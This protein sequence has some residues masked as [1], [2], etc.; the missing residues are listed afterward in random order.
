MA[1]GNSTLPICF[2]KIILQTNLQTI[3]IPNKFT[4]SHGVGLPNPMFIKPPD[5]TKWKM[6]WKNIN[7]EIWF[8]KGWSIFTQNYSLQHGCLVVFKY[9]EGTSELDVVILGQNALEIDYDSKCDTVDI[10]NVD[11]SDDESDEILNEWLNR[12][13]VR[14]KSPLVS[15]RAHKKVRGEIEKNTDRPSVPN[16]QGVIENKKTNVMIQIGERSWNLKLLPCYNNIRS[17]RLSAGWSLFARESGLQ[18]GDVCI[19][20]LINKKDLVFKVH[21]F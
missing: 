10:L 21:V 16:L 4:R 11:D 1:G 9:K 13:K 19:F 20:E 12:K 3:K 18:P 6:F 8:E 17:C 15:T 14:Q 2:F 5:G 7:G